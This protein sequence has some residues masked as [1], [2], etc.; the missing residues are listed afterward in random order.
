MWPPSLLSHPSLQENQSSESRPPAIP[1]SWNRSPCTVGVQK[2]VTDGLGGHSRSWGQPQASVPEGS[3]A[4]TPETPRHVPS[5]GSDSALGSGGDSPCLPRPVGGQTLRKAACDWPRMAGGHSSFQCLRAG[6]RIHVPLRL[7]NWDS[8]DG[9]VLP[10]AAAHAVRHTH[11]TV[12]VCSTSP[13][14]LPTH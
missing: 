1:C 6:D 2:A 12:Q 7:E 5:H 8:W 11:P 9:L 10:T 14:R 4:C 13:W 3:T